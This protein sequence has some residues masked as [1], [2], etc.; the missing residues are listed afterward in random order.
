M[1]APT[2]VEEAV[3]AALTADAGVIALVPAYKIKVGFAGQNLQEP[4]ITHFPVAGSPTHLLAELAALKTW[5]SYQVSVFGETYLSAKNV[6][7][8]VVAALGRLT[9]SDGVQFMLSGEPRF[10]GVDPGLIGS[11]TPDSIGTFHL[12]AEFKIFEAL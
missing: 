3:Q 9:T 5:E 2:F 10:M 12:M 8:A 1:S 4:Y 7:L 11:S 6:M